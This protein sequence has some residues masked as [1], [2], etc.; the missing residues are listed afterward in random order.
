MMFKIKT[1]YNAQQQG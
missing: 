1:H